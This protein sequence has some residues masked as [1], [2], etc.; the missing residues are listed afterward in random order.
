MA[1]THAIHVGHLGVHLTDHQGG[2]VQERRVATG[3]GAQGQVA[4]V[5]GTQRECILPGYIYHY[6]RTKVDCI[7]G[8]GGDLVWI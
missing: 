6:P 1:L 5:P 3:A 8:E 7:G 2:G 4:M